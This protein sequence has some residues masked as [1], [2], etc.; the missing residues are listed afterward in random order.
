[1]SKDFPLSNYCRHGAAHAPLSIRH[2]HRTVFDLKACL[3][4]PAKLERRCSTSFKMS[5]AGTAHHMKPLQRT[6][7]E[8][9]EI[10]TVANST[11]I[12]MVE[13]LIYSQ[14]KVVESSP[15]DFRRF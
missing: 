11:S 15:I 14:W 9:I 3:R 5:S 6:S 8:G 2:K 1:M 10:F 13:H 12:Q 7:S 4:I